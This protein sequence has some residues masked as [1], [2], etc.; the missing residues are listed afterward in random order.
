[1]NVLIIE[2]NPDDAYL[3]IQ[4]F[5]E[6]G[7]Q[8]KWIKVKNYNDFIKALD[9]VK[10]NNYNLIVC[11]MSLPGMPD[12]MS[13][14]DMLQ[15]VISSEKIEST[16]IPW[17]GF[18]SQSEI[19]KL[20]NRG[21]NFVRKEDI[22][23]TKDFSQIK[24][25]IEDKIPAHKT[26]TNTKRDLQSVKI[27]QKGATKDLEQV[28]RDL[29]RLSAELN[30]IKKMV[31]GGAGVEGID[32]QI[33]GLIRDIR[34]FKE[35]F[36]TNILLIQ[37]TVEASHSQLNQAE[38]RSFRE[39][40]SQRDQFTAE[41]QSIRVL[42]EHQVQQNQRSQEILIEENKSIKN[43]LSEVSTTARKN[44]EVLGILTLMSPLIG[45]AREKKILTSQVLLKVF[46][47]PV[48]GSI[49]GIVVHYFMNKK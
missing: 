39:M 33:N 2:D 44:A 35:S 14:I 17:S 10:T 40:K 46:F 9:E 21:L 22:L 30:E 23:S 29:E 48:V 28:R 45:W 31:F 16:I 34:S 4:N 12:R 18:V 26:T 5:T 15:G 25:F 3:A 36:A 42:F 11:D 20:N 37:K 41:L 7:Y 32:T 27:E 49:S 6:A 38:D 8:V 19:S 47:L 1:M 13:A 43:S 24:D